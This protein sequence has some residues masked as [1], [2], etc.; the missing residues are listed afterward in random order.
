M[1][2]QYTERTIPVDDLYGSAERVYTGQGVYANHSQFIVTSS[3]V[4]IDLYL[5]TPIPGHPAEPHAKFVQRIIL[6]H[7]S[8]K[9][10]VTGLANAVAGHEGKADIVIPNRREKAETDTIEI[11]K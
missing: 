8:V 2:E 11:W 1:S 7:S 5:V 4:F 9:G 6:P 10:F 3:E